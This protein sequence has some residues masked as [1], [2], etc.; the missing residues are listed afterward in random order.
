MTLNVES[1]SGNSGK[2]KFNKIQATPMS[3]VSACLVCSNVPDMD[4]TS[5]YRVFSQNTSENWK[6]FV[7]VKAAGN[8]CYGNGRNTMTKPSGGTL[9]F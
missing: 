6:N 5:Y 4:F 1:I 7:E 2:D 8:I 9:D 3:M